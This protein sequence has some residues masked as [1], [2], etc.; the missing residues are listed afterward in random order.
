MTPTLDKLEAEAKSKRFDA[1]PEDI[2][3]EGDLYKRLVDMRGGCRCFISPPC[4]ACCEPM[5]LDEADSLG[6]LDGDLDPNAAMIARDGVAAPKATPVSI[7]A[8]PT[9]H[10]AIAGLTFL[11]STDHR[12]GSAYR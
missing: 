8:A 11:A 7:P 4:S 12:L 3:E 10:K 6:L 2:L 5:S 1:L 9:G